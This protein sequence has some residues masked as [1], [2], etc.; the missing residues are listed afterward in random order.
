M[1]SINRTVVMM[2]S[3]HLH[4]VL[5]SEE[6]GGL[7]GTGTVISSDYAACGEFFNDWK[8]EIFKDL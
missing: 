4:Y 2:E 7:I 1:I 5:G 3:L 8:I 6:F